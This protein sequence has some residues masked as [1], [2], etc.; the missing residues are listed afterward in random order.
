[1]LTDC[2]VREESIHD[3]FLRSEH[4]ADL[5]DYVGALAKVWDPDVAS[6]VLSDVIGQRL[7][8]PAQHVIGLL[9]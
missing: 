8:G 4:Y 5:E 9:N 7:I 2:G 1:M 6:G 3:L